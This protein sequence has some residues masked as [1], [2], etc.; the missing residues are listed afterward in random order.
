MKQQDKSLANL[1]ITLYKLELLKKEEVN[2]LIIYVLRNS[3]SF[4]TKITNNHYF[5]K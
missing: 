4:E 3:L 1:L 2:H 5:I